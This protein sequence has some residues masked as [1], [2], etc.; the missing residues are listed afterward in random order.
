MIPI[1]ER[2]EACFFNIGKG[3]CTGIV[4]STTYGNDYWI[5]D[6]CSNQNSSNGLDLSNAYNSDRFEMA[7][8]IHNWIENPLGINFIITGFNEDYYN[9]IPSILNQFRSNTGVFVYTIPIRFFTNP[10]KDGELVAMGLDPLQN[11]EHIQLT[12]SIKR[13]YEWNGYHFVPRVS[14]L[15]GLKI[16]QSSFKDGVQ[17]LS[18]DAK[19]NS[20]VVK[21]KYG[22]SS[23]LIAGNAT[24]KTYESLKDLESTIFLLNQNGLAYLEKIKPEYVICSSQFLPSQNQPTPKTIEEVRKYFAGKNA[25]MENYHFFASNINKD[26]FNLG[27]TRK[28]QDNFDLKFAPVMSMVQRDN[29]T[30]QTKTIY[31]TNYPFFHTGT[32]GTVCIQLFK[33]PLGSDVNTPHPKPEIKTFDLDE[34]MGMVETSQVQLFSKNQMMENLKILFQFW[35]LNFSPLALNVIGEKPEFKSK[36]FEGFGK[37]LEILNLRH[38]GL[39]N[40]NKNNLSEILRLFPFVTKIAL[41]SDQIQDG[42]VEEDPCAARLLDM[43]F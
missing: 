36:D 41:N 6:A 31:M 8:T 19:D 33:N 17:F 25:G 27:L 18:N 39:A 16:V 7:Q 2:V 5:I 22:S 21:F 20:L 23:I 26:F 24:A 38:S 40:L 9:L 15:P 10:M 13:E 1:T 3:S 4:H 43:D 12:D 42:A 37:E 32:N 11:A 14:V 34:N 30:V 35:N 29:S 28:S